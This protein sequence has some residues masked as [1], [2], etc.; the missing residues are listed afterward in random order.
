MEKER[1]EK[2]AWDGRYLYKVPG[3]GRIAGSALE[4][5]RTLRISQSACRIRL[6]EVIWRSRDLAAVIRRSQ[7]D[8][9]RTAPNHENQRGGNDGSIPVSTSN[10]SD[11]VNCA[12]FQLWGWDQ[13]VAGRYSRCVILHSHWL[14]RTVSLSAAQGPT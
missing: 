12:T 10:V 7:G 8:L 1:W 14:K 5:R 3:E 6:A 4:S 11:P 13:D 9:A 2:R